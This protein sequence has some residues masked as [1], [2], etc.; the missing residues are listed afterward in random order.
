MGNP[1]KTL[2]RVLRG[3]A[4]ANIAFRDMR[5]LLA[6]LEFD[7]RVRGSD[8]IYT[9]AGVDEIL[10]LQARQGKCKPYQVKQV[11]QVILKYRLAGGFDA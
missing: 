3:N 2:A 5:R 10:N 11:R 9:R 8:H 1:G 4:D 6:A 7:E